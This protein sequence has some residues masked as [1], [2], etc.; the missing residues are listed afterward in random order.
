[1][2]LRRH[3]LNL[4]PMLEALLRH[5][6]VTRAG[7]ELGL[8]QSAM[9]HA[10]FRLR[11]HFG[12]KLLVASGREMVLTPRAESLKALVQDALE[13]V[14]RVLET[15]AFEPATSE[16]RFNLCTADYVALLLLPAILQRL[17]KEA[18]NVTIQVTWDREDMPAKLRS[19]QL[20]FVLVPRGALVEDD[21]HSETLFADELV[22]VASAN[23]PDIGDTLDY[24]T[25]ERLPHAVF[26][27]ENSSSK[28]FADIQLSHN[29][30]H[31]GKEALVVSDFLLL[32]FVIA[33][34]SHI[35][36]LHRRLAE[37][38]CTATQVKFLAPPFPTEKLYVE[39]YW[40]HQAQGDPGHQWFRQILRDACAG[41]RPAEDGVGAKAA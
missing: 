40:A 29:K 11:E 10:L 4:L 15:Q 21:L 38:M 41:L 33:E 24:A 26:R 22:V 9:S 30:L 32:P 12:D 7:D 2:T 20:D 17:E 6:N 36:L 14:T 39:A 13:C 27:K 1:M 35:A 37:R 28:S 5:R 19:N 8:S 23:H 25:Y 31:H 16:R 18:P 3:D 34:T